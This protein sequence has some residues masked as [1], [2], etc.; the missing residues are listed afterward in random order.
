FFLIPR[1]GGLGA[2]WATIVTEAF[3]TV[4]LLFALRRDMRKVDESSN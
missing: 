3:L 2:A 4:A 1:F